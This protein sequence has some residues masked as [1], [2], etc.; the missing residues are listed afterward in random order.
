MPPDAADYFGADVLSSAL[1]GIDVAVRPDG[2]SRVLLRV[3]DLAPELPIWVTENG[4]G[5]WD[6]LDPDGT[7]ND[8]E[9]VAF[10]DGYTAALADA[11]PATPFTVSA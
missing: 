5:L 10:L 4:I 8:V 9:R 6:Y 2:F 3:A 1:D 7:C 11:R